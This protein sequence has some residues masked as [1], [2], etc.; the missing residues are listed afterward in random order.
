MAELAGFAEGTWYDDF[1]NEE[2][3]SM[4]SFDEGE[5]GNWRSKRQTF[6]FDME[7]DDVYSSDSEGQV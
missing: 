3:A 4:A 7:H 6:F 2:N 5:E 1:R